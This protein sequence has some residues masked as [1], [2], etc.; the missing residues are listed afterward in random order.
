MNLLVNGLLNNHTMKFTAQVKPFSNACSFPILLAQFWLLKISPEGQV[1]PNPSKSDSPL[2]LVR[3]AWRAW[4]FL[5]L[6]QG[7]QGRKP[8]SPPFCLSILWPRHSA[9]KS[10]YFPPQNRNRVTAPGNWKRKALWTLLRR[11]AEGEFVS[12]GIRQNNISAQMSR[13]HTEISLPTCIHK[14]YKTFVPNH[15]GK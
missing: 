15:L 12:V 1:L 10:K 14:E 11:K 6:K 4:L 8:S 2:H 9:S 7:L 5:R 3:Q 13:I